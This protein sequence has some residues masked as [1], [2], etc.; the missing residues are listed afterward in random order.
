[1]FKL[2]I[3]ILT[4]SHIILAASSI[5]DPSSLCTPLYLYRIQ[6]LKYL[7]KL[8]KHEINGNKDSTKY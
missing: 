8:Y 4:L 7:L 6:N 5:V 1:M 3:E 2:L